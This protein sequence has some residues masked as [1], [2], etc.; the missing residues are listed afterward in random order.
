MADKYDL[1]KEWADLNAKLEAGWAPL[2][3]LVA[4]R[5]EIE[6][7]FP[8][9][10]NQG[11]SPFPPKTSPPAPSSGLSPSMGTMLIS[12]TDKKRKKEGTEKV[13][14]SKMNKLEGQGKGEKTS[15]TEKMSLDESQTFQGRKD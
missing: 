8:F 10:K 2:R 1:V 6:K 7:T 11:A 13:I 9:L 3:D 5:D 15:G 14:R 4:R 12:P